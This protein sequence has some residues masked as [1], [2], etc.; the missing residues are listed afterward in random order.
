MVKLFYNNTK[1]AVVDGAGRSDWLTVKTGVKQGCVIS[2][3]LFQMVVDWIMCR[4]TEQGD[5]GI[6]WKMMRQLEE[7]DFADDKV[8]ISSI[9]RQA[10]MKA[11][12]LG[13]NSEGTD[14]KINIDKT[15]MLKLNARRQL[16]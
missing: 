11:E 13:R 10:Q 12:R 14:L 9:R 6:R 5:T 8:L 15:K 16:S 7:L 2:G 1:C 3:F 4:T